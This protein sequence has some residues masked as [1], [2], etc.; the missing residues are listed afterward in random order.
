MFVSNGNHNLIWYR[1]VVYENGDTQ[2][3]DVSIDRLVFLFMW[4]LLSKYEAKSD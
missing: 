3:S 4:C 2:I 1:S